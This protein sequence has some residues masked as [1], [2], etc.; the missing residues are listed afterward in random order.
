MQK[1]KIKQLN[2]GKTSQSQRIYDT[3]GISCQLTSQGGGQGAKTGLYLIPEATKQGYAVAKEGDSINLSNPKSKTRRGRVGVANTIDRQME[4]YTL[5][6][7]RIR[8]LTPIEC[9]RLQGFPDNWTQGISDSQRYKCLGN[10]V[11][12]PVVKAVMERLFN[13]GKNKG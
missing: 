1:S 4:Q 7:A 8:R 12:V 2:S 6:G 13:Q 10:A 9:E 5:K 11:S 3:G